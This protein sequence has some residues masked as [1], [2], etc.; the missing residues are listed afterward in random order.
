MSAALAENEAFP[1][2]MGPACRP[3]LRRNCLWSVAGNAVYGACQWGMLIV[4]AK[5]TTPLQV[6]QFAYALAVTAP[7]L[8][9]ANLQLRAVQ[10]TDAREEYGFGDYLG[11]RLLTSAL[12]LLT[13]GFLALFTSSETGLVVLII[14]AAKIIES[15][16]DVIYGLLQHHER[17]D[18]LA[19]SLLTK[20]PLSLL[21]LA[22]GVWLTG[23]VVWGAVGLLAAWLIVLL[24]YD[25]PRAALARAGGSIR[26]R[27]HLA[28]LTRLGRLAL[29]LGFVMMLISLNANL[30]RYFLE[31]FRGEQDLGIFAALATL[32][33]VGNTIICAIGQAASPR[34]AL[35]HAAGQRS[36]FLRLL[37]HLLGVG[38]LLGA[39]GVAVAA[40]WGRELLTLLYRPLYAQHATELVW[41]MAAGGL[42][43]LA[44]FL[45]YSLTAVRRFAV[46]MPLSIAVTLC[47]GLA[48]WWLAPGLGLLGAAYALT[49]SAAIQ[50]ILYALALLPVLRAGGNGG[51]EHG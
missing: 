5:L 43:Y 50:V 28:T 41:L 6:G 3:S 8:M 35:A 12:A 10:A 36:T 4:L 19:R 16:S 2:R 32:A 14:G 15:V 29:P 13:I 22:A 45:G 47:T 33:L 26:P 17:M 51:R 37:A 38:L 49:I 48:C 9:L 40:L 46:Q 30:P 44:S 18:W 24:A 7:V 34:L 11:L 1:A 42:G 27:W 31:R 25:C 39:V 21:A 23:S 20:G